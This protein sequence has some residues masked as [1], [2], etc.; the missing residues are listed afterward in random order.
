M[1]PQ[2]STGLEQAGVLKSLRGHERARENTFSE[3]KAGYDKYVAAD[4]NRKNSQLKK[5]TTL[6]VGAGKR[7]EK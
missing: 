7:S 3:W 1:L 5:L 2:P 4:L 6:S